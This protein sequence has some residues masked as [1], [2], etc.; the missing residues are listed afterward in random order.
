MSAKGPQKYVHSSHIKVTHRVGNKEAEL[1]LAEMT[2]YT[3][4]IEGIYNS[5][6][7]FPC[8]CKN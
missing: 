2:F 3:K 8:V 6:S 1:S 7:E 5:T 4:S